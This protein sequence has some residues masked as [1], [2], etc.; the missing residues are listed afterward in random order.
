MAGSNQSKQTVLTVR[1]DSNLAEQFK[2]ISKE[3][4]RNQ[5]QLVRDWVLSYVKKNGQGDLFK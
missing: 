4:N 2:K 3:N 5:S 1:M